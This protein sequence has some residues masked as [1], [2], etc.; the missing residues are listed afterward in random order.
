[1]ISLFFKL[2][3]IKLLGWRI[4]GDYPFHEKKLIIVVAPHTSF[5]DFGVGVAVRGYLNFKSNY[6]AKKELFNNPV[7]SWFLTN[8]G[9]VPV[10]RGNKNVDVVGQTI[11]LFKSRE[12]FVIA[13]TPEGTRA[14]VEK[15]K[16]GFYRIAKGADVPIL[17]AGF[18]FK[19]KTCEFLPP[20]KPGDDMQ[21]DIDYIMDFFKTKTGQNPQLDLRPIA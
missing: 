14:R 7:L 5:W 9:G 10:D 18:D 13:L 20:F 8:T 15:L 19:E 21:K 4:V 17:V 6:L 2:V 16:T 11:E 3:F 1:M 12:E